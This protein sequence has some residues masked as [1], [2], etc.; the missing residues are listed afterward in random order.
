MAR[1]SGVSFKRLADPIRSASFRVRAPPPP[2]PPLA[3]PA[4]AA[5]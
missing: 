4:A 5:A 3:L 1:S 2:P